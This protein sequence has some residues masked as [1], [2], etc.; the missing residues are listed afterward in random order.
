MSDRVAFRALI[1]LAGL[2]IFCLGCILVGPLELLR[3][4]SSLWLVCCSLLARHMAMTM[5]MANPISPVVPIIAWLFLGL[6]IGSSILVAWRLWQATRCLTRLTQMAC[7]LHPPVVARLATRLKLNDSLVVVAGHAPISFCYGLWRPHICLSLGLVD[8]LT[9]PELEAVLR[10]E[11]YHLQRREPLRMAIAICLSRFFFFVP[12]LAELCDRYLAEKELSADAMAAASTSRAALAGA[13]YKLITVK[14]SF[15]LPPLA[16]VAGLSVTAQR[17][18]RLIAPSVK[19]V[20][21]PSRRS[22]FSTLAVFALGCL[23]ML[24]GVS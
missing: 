4:G 9:E 16:T 18:D 19:P 10:H 21:V 23:F 15:V 14:Q 2:L 17:V 13:L 11:A 1:I 7:L 20:W 5:P 24:V 8:L 3:L 22:I 6:M 12:L